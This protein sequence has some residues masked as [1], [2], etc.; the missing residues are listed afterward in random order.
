M[1]RLALILVASLALNG[2]LIAWFLARPAI[3]PPEM[4]GWFG[5]RDAARTPAH[6]AA[7]RTSTPSTR[8]S[9]P[10]ALSWSALATDDLTVFV[11]RLRAAGFPPELVRAMIMAAL[12]AR[13]SPRI[14]ELVSAAENVPFWQSDGSTVF[15][16][17]QSRAELDQLRRDRF[18][19]LRELLGSDMFASAG[20]DPTAEQRRQYGNLNGAKIDLLERINA[21]YAEM[22][23][24][25]RAAMQD[26][27][28]P[29]DR[30]KLELLE[31]ERRADLAALLTPQELADYAMR[32]SPTFGRARAAL[33]AM[34]ATEEEF[35]AIF[36]I[37]H[38]Y[39]DRLYPLAPEVGFMASAQRREANL[40]MAG[41][42]EAALG[43]QRYGDFLRGSSSE[44]RQLSRLA[45]DN[46][47]PPDAAVRAFAV[48]SDVSSQSR[49]I[50]SDP[51]QDEAQKRAA[52]RALAQSARTQILNTLGPTAGN[53]YLQRATWLGAVERGNAMTFLP[54]STIA[55]PVPRAPT[56]P[57]N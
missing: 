41:Q 22:S 14:R 46:G 17:P 50:V 1:K 12:D 26:I 24:Q 2:A 31:R 32:S 47:L 23:A 43:P 40:Q 15:A 52:L 25:I 3:A 28:L 55:T 34:D 9:S 37:Q 48:R 10:P 20:S 57:R 11:A 36:A 4:R 54:D 39:E 19:L 7:S 21:D 27:V 6:P 16:N 56:A 45:D 35:R 44:F 33:G 18:K 38:A 42:L 51:S 30:A 8:A 29:E 13:F 5:P 53:T 49:R